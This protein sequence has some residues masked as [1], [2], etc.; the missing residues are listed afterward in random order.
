[1]SSIDKINVGGTIYDIKDSKIIGMGSGRANSLVYREE[2]TEITSD[3]WQDISSGNFEKVHVGM[4]YTAPSGRTYWF[5][6]ANYNKGMGNTEQTRNTM[7]V[8]EDEISITSAHHS[9]LT[10]E[11]GAV[12]SDIYTTV[13]PAHQGE[14]ETDFG[15]EH[16]IPQPI[17]LTNAVTNGVVSSG[18][19]SSLYSFI[20]TEKQIFGNDI[21]YTDGAYYYI[22]FTARER[23]LALFANM[24]ETII[25]HEAGT[26]NRKSYWTDTVES[27]YDFGYA[28]LAGNLSLTGASSVPGVRRAFF[29]G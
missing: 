8:I 18:A 9:T 16:I 25:A 3:M 11:G 14:L 23:Q 15:A 22:N 6:H 13:L 12:A 26:T 20:L 2:I 4:H 17:Y 5:A 10:T 1:M 29:I 7:L 24:P 28:S 21:R 27:V 19:W